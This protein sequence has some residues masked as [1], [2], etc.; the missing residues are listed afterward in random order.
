MLGSALL[1]LAQ[2]EALAQDTE[3]LF[4][5]NS[6]TSV[7]D[8]T[9]LVQML[10][11]A[12]GHG[13][14]KD[15]HAPGGNTLGAPQS[16]GFPHSMHPTSIA[17][18]N[19]ADWDYVV[20]QEQTVIPAVPSAKNAY[21][22]PAG[23]DLQ[24]LISANFAGT[25]TFLYQTW[26]RRDPG[27]YCWTAHCGT[28]AN[29]NEMQDSL[30]AA[31]DELAVQIG[32]TVI[33]VG[34]AW[35]RAFALSP[36]IELHSADGSHP[37]F[38]GT[39]LSACVFY[40]KIFNESPEG[41]SFIAHLDPSVAAFLQTVAAETVFG[42]V[43]TFC[44]AK[45]TSMCGAANIS[46]NGFS[47]ATL[48]SGFVIKAQPVRGCRAGLLLY[49]DQPTVTGIP[50]GGPGDGLLCINGMGLRRAGPI[51]SGSMPQFC[52]GTLAI[53]MNKFRSFNWVAVGCN[54]PFGQNNPA[55]FLG[56]MG[57][58]VNAQMWGR[59]SIATGQI[60]SDGLSWSVGP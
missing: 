56:N 3:I 45:T 43:T 10:A 2:G 33:P 38:A 32:A 25:T 7:N 9:G 60:L 42:T 6:Y 34:E 49:S 19:S 39:Y 28:F 44:T 26:G 29:F 24:A 20:L 41:S 50:F 5:G 12:G 16:S 53:D 11:Q 4:L 55:G 22:L 47:S 31:Y 51:Q 35:R 46:A 13:L 48:A 15:F 37:S 1:A 57:T 59:D 36:T 27:T 40:A 52:D 54:P 8:L 30:T 18:I 17:K 23:Q 21:M 58:T 14:V